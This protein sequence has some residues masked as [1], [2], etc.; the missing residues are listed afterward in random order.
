[1][2]YAIPYPTGNPASEN[3]CSKCYRDKKNMDSAAAPVVP[4]DSTA[5]SLPSLSQVHAMMNPALVD[6]D[7]GPAVMTPPVPVITPPENETCKTKILPTTTV[8]SGGD[9][10]TTAAAASPKKPKKP[11]CFSCRKK[12]RIL[13]L[14]FL[15]GRFAPQY[16]VSFFWL[17]YDVNLMGS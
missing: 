1:M 15:F 7:A 8:V 3:Y 9:D 6:A 14:L 10:G 5:P 17:R 16:V 11:R 2:K 12:V 13:R 4:M